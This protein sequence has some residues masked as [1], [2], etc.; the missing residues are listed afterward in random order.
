M[1]L[2]RFGKLVGRTLEA[3]RPKPSRNRKESRTRIDT[4]SP[5][6]LERQLH[7]AFRTFVQNTGHLLEQ[8]GLLGNFW[9]ETILYKIV[10]P[11][12]SE[13]FR[14]VEFD[15]KELPTYDLTMWECRA[16]I[17][18]FFTQLS[19]VINQIGTAIQKDG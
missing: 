17:P 6:I 16:R 1:I 9:G 19:A 8:K 3:I 12:G 2:A 4:T 15:K 11:P 10:K 18:R 5:S 13:H 14:L 7:E